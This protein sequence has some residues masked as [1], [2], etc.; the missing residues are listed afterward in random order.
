[1]RELKLSG[2]IIT[3]EQQLWMRFRGRQTKE[4]W[5]LRAPYPASLSLVNDSELVVVLSV[6]VSFNVSSSPSYGASPTMSVGS[7]VSFISSFVSTELSKIFFGIVFNAIIFC[8]IV[9]GMEDWK[10]AMRLSTSTAND[11]EA[12]TPTKRA[13]C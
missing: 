8:T 13:I 6:S 9:V 11:Y 1:M 5:T 7:I 12:S 10:W 3:I 2:G 4:E